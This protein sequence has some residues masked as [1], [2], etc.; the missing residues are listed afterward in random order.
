LPPS[1]EWEEFVNSLPIAEL[2]L[3][4]TPEDINAGKAR[5][6]WIGELHAVC[7]VGYPFLGVNVIYSQENPDKVIRRDK[8]VLDI[9]IPL[10]TLYASDEHQAFVCVRSDVY[11]LA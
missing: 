11:E 2:K 9:G 5:I 4:G 3:K 6:E 10:R 8:F 7:Y 1:D